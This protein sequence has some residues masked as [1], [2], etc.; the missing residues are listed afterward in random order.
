[1]ERILQHT[2]LHTFR[3]L[4]RP[5]AGFSI[6]NR[7]LAMRNMGVCGSIKAS[8][9]SIDLLTLRQYYCLRN[10]LLCYCANSHARTLC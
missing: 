8:F 4:N 3:Q 6:S 2:I 9:S 7:H 10:Q 1:M 5:V